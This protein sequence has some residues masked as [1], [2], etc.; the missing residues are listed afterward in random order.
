M[1]ICDLRLRL[2]QGTKTTPE[3]TFSRTTPG[4]KTEIESQVIP[5]KFFKMIN[6]N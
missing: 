1:A 6:E 2:L 3:E 4:I 5:F